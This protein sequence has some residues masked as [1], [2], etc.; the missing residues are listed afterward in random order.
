M[1]AAKITSKGTLSTLYSF[2][3]QPNCSD[4]ELPTGPLVQGSDGNFYGTTQELDSDGPGTVFKITPA[5]AFANLHT[6]CSQPNCADG[7]TPIGEMIQ[8]TGGNLTELRA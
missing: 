8:A 1:Q 2:C 6:F 5:G 3:L 7:Q 4:G